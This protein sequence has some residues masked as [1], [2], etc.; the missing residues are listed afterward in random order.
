MRKY[1]EEGR[2]LEDKMNKNLTM[3][4]NRLQQLE[5]NERAIGGVS[6]T[7]PSSNI[8]VSRKSSPPVVDLTTNVVVPSPKHTLLT[9]TSTK[10]RTPTRTT[11]RDSPSRVEITPHN[12][13]P[14]V[15]QSEY[16][17]LRGID[18]AMQQMIMREI[19]DDSPGVEWDDVGE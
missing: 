17:Q 18:K 4:H 7:T 19:V 3:V 5:G 14:V 8:L 2:V 10:P 16:P 12:V 9:P 6:Y 1:S 13:S 11:S 15:R